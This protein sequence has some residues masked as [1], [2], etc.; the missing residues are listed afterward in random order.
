M[1]EPFLE[2]S[3]YENIFLPIDIR[4]PLA[5]TAFESALQY[6]FVLQVFHQPQ[7]VCLL[8]IMQSSLLF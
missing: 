4:R 8:R 5:K 6:H 7:R 2:N 3:L 1:Q